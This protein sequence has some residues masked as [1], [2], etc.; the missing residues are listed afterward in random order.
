MHRIVE[1]LA[2][3]RFDEE[4]CQPWIGF[5]EPTPE[6]DAVGLVDDAV[7][8][9]RGEVCEDRLLHQVGMQR[10]DAVNVRRSNEGEMAHA[11]ALAL[12][13]LDQRDGRKLGGIGAHG[14]G[15]PLQVLVV[16]EEDDLHVPRQQVVHEMQ[17]P[18]L[19]RLGKQRVVGVVQSALGD[20]PGFAPRQSVLVDEQA[21]Q[22]GHRNCRVSVVHVDRRAIGEGLDRLVL[23]QV[24]ADQ[25]LQRGRG[26]EI[27]LTQTQRLSRRRLVRRVEHARNRFGVGAGGEGSDVVAAIEAGEVD[28]IHGSG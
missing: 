3:E 25:V 21:H 23:R 10:R 7:G 15:H 1:Y 27:L 9:D 4:G 6:G 8:I 24:T 18:G 19:E 5:Y 28:L 22:L 20:R 12:A 13:L 14:L 11:D 2:P 16:D 26:E 17:R